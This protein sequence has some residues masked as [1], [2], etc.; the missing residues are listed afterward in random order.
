MTRDDRRVQ[1]CHVFKDADVLSADEV[2]ATVVI[3]TQQN[4]WISITQVEGYYHDRDIDDLS[5]IDSNYSYPT[6]LQATVEKCEMAEVPVSKFGVALESWCL[7]PLEELQ[8]DV[9][10]VKSL[11]LPLE[12]LLMHILSKYLLIALTNPP[13]VKPCL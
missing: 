3:R 11:T 7:S 9:K 5:Q 2:E 12:L 10:M 4:D 13:E 6:R 1:A 8:A